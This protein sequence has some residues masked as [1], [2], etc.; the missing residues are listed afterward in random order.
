MNK[1]KQYEGINP[2]G[3]YIDFKDD[4]GNII[5]KARNAGQMNW[6]YVK[7]VNPYM[8]KYYHKGKKITFTLNA[9]QFPFVE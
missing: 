8:C 5:T 9:G 3:L 7:G 4:E 1:S 6:N 2:R